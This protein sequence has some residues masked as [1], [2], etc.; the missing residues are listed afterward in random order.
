[1]SETIVSMAWAM[2]NRRGINHDG[3]PETGSRSMNQR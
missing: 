1:M 3:M 2:R